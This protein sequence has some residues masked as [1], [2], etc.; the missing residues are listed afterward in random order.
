[1][2]NPALKTDVPQFVHRIKNVANPRPN[3]GIAK[4]SKA[5]SS[6]HCE[7]SITNIGNVTKAIIMTAVSRNPF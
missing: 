3:N 2:P 7:P 5:F 6:I 4:T 1:M